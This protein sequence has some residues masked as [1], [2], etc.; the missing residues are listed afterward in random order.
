MITCD[1]S[2]Q[3]AYLWHTCYVWSGIKQD[4]QTIFGGNAKLQA[5]NLAVKVINV[6]LRLNEYRVR[7]P[8]YW[9]YN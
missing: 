3:S 9:N 1:K 8:Y 7:L 2:K 5:N 4:L 6:T